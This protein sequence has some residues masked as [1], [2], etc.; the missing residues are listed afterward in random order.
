MPTI[1]LTANGQRNFGFSS[2]FGL[3]LILMS[4]WE[5]LLGIIALGL[6][7]GGPSGLLYSYLA[8]F[9]CFTAV[10]ASM[11]EMASMAPTSGGQYHWVSE[12]APTQ[13]QKRLSYLTGWLSVLGYQIGV[14]ITAFSAG[15]VIQGLIIL[16]YTETYVPE[17]WHATVIAMGITLCIAVL[18]IFFAG[19]LPL[20]EGIVMVLH[21]GVWTAIVVVLW[22]LGPRTSNANV[23]NSF[24]DGDWGDSEYFMTLMR[25][26]H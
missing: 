1:K 13:F 4:S 3:S 14:T 25:N 12:F 17:R 11:A 6:S 24:V 18:N 20:V 16:N 19:Q 21:V 2:I 8:S 26:I 15:L 9:I 10:V 7:N 22:A 23:W 5:S